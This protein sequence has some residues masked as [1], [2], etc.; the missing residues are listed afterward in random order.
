MSPGSPEQIFEQRLAHVGLEIDALVE[1]AVKNPAIIAVQDA[2]TQLML[3]YLRYWR[4]D[5]G[6]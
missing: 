2:R 1:Q 6:H 3:S 5:R 4:R